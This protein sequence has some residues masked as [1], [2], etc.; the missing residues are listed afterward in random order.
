MRII[1]K[2]GDL[3]LSACLKA[4]GVIGLMF[5]PLIAMAEG[6]TKSPWQVG[7]NLTS[8]GDLTKTVGDYMKEIFSYIG[9]FVGAL[10]LIGAAIFIW[11]TANMPK[12]EK[13]HHNVPVRMFMGIAAGVIGMGLIVFLISG[14]N[15]TT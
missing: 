3:Y 8:G 7:L 12:D 4:V 1:E 2:T 5:A 11:Q 6:P 15:T 10:I 13:E 14:L 9:V